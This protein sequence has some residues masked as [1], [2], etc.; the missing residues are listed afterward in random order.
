MNTVDSNSAD[1]KMLRALAVND[2]DADAWESLYTKYSGLM[3]GCILK[4]TSDKKSA[5]VIFKNIFLNLKSVPFPAHDTKS[6]AFWLWQHTRAAA[7]D[8][9]KRNNITGVRK[10]NAFPILGYLCFNKTTLRDASAALHIPEQEL[11][12]QVKLELSGKN[13]LT[14]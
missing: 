3:Y 11:R 6:F 7:F 4:I 1:W 8:Q 2:N 9:V 10:K 13:G 12:R 5:E 14:L